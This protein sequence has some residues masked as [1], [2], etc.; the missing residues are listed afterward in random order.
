[1]VPVPQRPCAPSYP[2]WRGWDSFLRKLINNSSA[3]KLSNSASFLVGL[4]DLLFKKMAVLT[5]IRTALFAG[6]A[7]AALIARDYPSDDPL[8]KC[9]GYKASNVQTTASGLTADLTL[10]GE[11][12]N[13]YGDDLKGL[14]LTVSYD[15]GTCAS[16]FNAFLPGR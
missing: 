15:T 10:A 9:P 5:F 12:C 13:T 16:C 4:R 14:T 1:M 8:A 11:A 3:R 6:A 2:A 7:S